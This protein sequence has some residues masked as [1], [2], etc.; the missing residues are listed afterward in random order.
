MHVNVNQYKEAKSQQ[1]FILNGSFMQILSCGRIFV[2]LKDIFL[3]ES[4]TRLNN[5]LS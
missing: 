3:T 5:T 2:T 1:I 4:V